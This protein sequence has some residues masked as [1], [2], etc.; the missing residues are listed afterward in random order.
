MMIHE[1]QEIGRM[2]TSCFKTN[3]IHHA[4]KVALG[5]DSICR[6]GAQQDEGRGICQEAW[7]PTGL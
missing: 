7:Y 3:G 4:C 1:D 2:L 6:G 5:S